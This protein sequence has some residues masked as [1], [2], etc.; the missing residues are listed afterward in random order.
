MSESTQSEIKKNLFK[1]GRKNQSFSGNAVYGLGF[2]GASIYYVSC[3]TSFW[4]G[5]LGILKALVWPAFLV[6]GLLQYITI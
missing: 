6:Y 1:R 5:V 3:A 2:I 4:I